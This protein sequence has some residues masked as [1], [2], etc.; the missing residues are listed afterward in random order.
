L[1]SE[2]ITRLSEEAHKLGIVLTTQNAKDIDRF[3]DSLRTLKESFGGLWLNISLLIIPILEKLTKFLTDA[4]IVLREF[5]E[6]HPILARNIATLTLVFGALMLAIGPLLIAIPPLIIMFAALDVALAPVLGTILIIVGAIGALTLVVAN[7]K[8]I[9]QGFLKFLQPTIEFWTGKKFDIQKPEEKN[10]ESSETTASQTTVLDE[11]ITKVQRH[12][13]ALKELNENYLTGK[14]N[15]EDYYNEVQKLHIDGLDIK[16]QELELL[17]Q[18]IELEYLAT[19]AEYQKIYVMQQGIQSAQEYYRVKAELQNQD[20]MDQQITLNSATNLLRTIEGMHK[21]IWQGI[22]DFVNMGIQKFSSGFSTALTGIIMGTKTAGEAFKEFGVAMLQAIVEFVVQYAVQALIAMTIGGWIT[23]ATIAFADGIAAAWLPAA[24]LASIATMGAAD[25]AGTAALGGAMASSIGMLAAMKGAQAAS[26][27]AG[28]TTMAK[29][30]SGIATKPTLFLAGEAGPERYS[31][32][33]LDKE[34]GGNTYGD[35][36]IEL[37]AIINN[38]MDIKEVAEKLGSEIE[39][40]LR[41][42]RRSI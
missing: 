42:A 26:A 29:G 3:G 22:F 36:N 16:Q 9:W 19:D 11:T 41:G 40:Q 7:A 27:G 15:A 34:G 31:F 25:A 38:D 18:S 12:T 37:N 14:I 17:R 35:I 20:L 1:G 30:G 2:G 5:S 4:I 28:L 6:V 23:A 10:K 32:T 8:N 21:T 24:I 39:Q 33:P 13:E